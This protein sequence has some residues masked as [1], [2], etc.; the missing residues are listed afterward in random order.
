M[1]LSTNGTKQPTV[2]TPRAPV[3]APFPRTF[4]MPRVPGSN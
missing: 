1:S 4:K 3:N 2:Q